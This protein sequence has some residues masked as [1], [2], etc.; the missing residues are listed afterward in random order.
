MT[1][2]K[3]AVAWFRMTCIPSWWSDCAE[4]GEEIDE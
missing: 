3:L 1:S 4:Y 2:F